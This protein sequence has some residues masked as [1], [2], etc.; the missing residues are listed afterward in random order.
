MQYT[1]KDSQEKSYLQTAFTDPIRQELGGAVGLC[2]HNIKH[3][4]MLQTRSP[5]T[6]G[7][8]IGFIMQRFVREGISFNRLTIDTKR[9]WVKIQAY[10]IKEQNCMRVEWL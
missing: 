5:F 4:A 2:Y 8:L 6:L 9:L 3:T 7:L 1:E 10:E